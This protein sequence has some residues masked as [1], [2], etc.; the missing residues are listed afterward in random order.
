MTLLK[1]VVVRTYT[2]ISSSSRRHCEAIRSRLRSDDLRSSS[3]SFGDI[4]ST[5]RRDA[6]LSPSIDDVVDTVRDSHVCYIE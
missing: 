5:G 6:E 2:G 1:I 3:G 4:I